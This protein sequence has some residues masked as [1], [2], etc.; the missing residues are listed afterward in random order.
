MEFIEGTNT[1]DIINYSK[2]NELL[3]DIFQ[4]KKDI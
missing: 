3:E 1:N 4:F 2:T